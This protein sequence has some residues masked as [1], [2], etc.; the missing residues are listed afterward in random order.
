MQPLARRYMFNLAAIGATLVSFLFSWFVFGTAVTRPW[1]AI[2]Y[3]IF[4]AV[5]L[6]RPVLAQHRRA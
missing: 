2:L 6:L 1:I 4:G 3:F 5:F